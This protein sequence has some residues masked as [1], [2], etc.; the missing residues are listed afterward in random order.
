MRKWA[1]VGFRTDIIGIGI[2]I[3]I[4]EAWPVVQV[5][6]N[7]QDVAVTNYTAEEL[8]ENTSDQSN[9]Q[10][11]FNE[12]AM[13]RQQKSTKCGRTLNRA[14]ELECLRAVAIPDANLNTQSLKACLM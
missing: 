3:M 9:G 12:V 7:R 13:C 5:Y 8:Q 2:V 10:F 6:L 4:N 14:K 1:F 11:D